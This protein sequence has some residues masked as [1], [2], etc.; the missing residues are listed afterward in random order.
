MILIFEENFA[1]NDY[2]VLI[3]RLI[4]QFESL[5]YLI[6]T[7]YLRG[8][9]AVTCAYCSRIY[10]TRYNLDEHI[11]SRHAGLPPPP[12]LSV[13]FSRTEPRYQCQIAHCSMVFTDVADFNAHRQICGEEQRTDLLGQVD[14][15]QNNKNLVDTSDVTSI[16]SDDDNKEFRSAEAKL[17]KN[18]QLTILKQAL[19]KGDSLKRN[20]D[21]DGSITSSK[22]RKI[23]KTGKLLL[24]KNYRNGRIFN[25]YSTRINFER[26]SF[27][28]QRNKFSKEVVLRIVSAKFHVG[29]QFEGA[30]N[31]TRNR[32]TVYMLA[33]QKRF[34][35]ED[36]IE[37]AHSNVARRRSCS[38]H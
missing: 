2:I 16:D 13:P 25:V 5:M 14:A 20:Y 23:V 30:R 3:Y 19:T 37:Q 35:V 31:Y 29:G 10:S 1:Q 32:E 33:V 17:A 21:D 8:H 22:P 11:K 9:P 36:F 26:F 12:E 28:R 6:G 34:Y 18:P 7:S 15:A 4:I 24:F 27:R 38:F